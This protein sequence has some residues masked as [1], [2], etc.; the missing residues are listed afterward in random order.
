VSDLHVGCAVEGRYVAHS[1]AA[2]HSVLGQSGE[3]RVHVHYLHGP[4]LPAEGQGSLTEMVERM[5]GEISFVHVLDELVEGLPTEGFTR[6]ATWYRGLVADVLPDLERILFLDADLLA[7]D[8]LGPLWQTDVSG[9]YLAAVTNVFQ[10]DHLSR[11]AQLGL[12]RPEAYFNAGV[13]LMNLE[14]MRRDGCTAAIRDYGRSHADHLMFRDQDA[15]NVVLG[16]RRLALHPRWNCMNALHFFPWSAYVFGNRALAEARAKPAIRHFEGPGIN[17]PWV[18]G[19]WSPQRE[20]YFEH[21]R[22]TPWPEVEIEEVPS[23]PGR[24]ARRL[25]RRFSA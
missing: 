15:L 2:L 6:K 20:L 4:E 8:A 22:G 12:D 11:P 16:E 24:I 18:H 9:H 7:L 13:M 5:G 21:R 17:K 14:L 25:R 3:F 23:L 10:A 19:S 1:A